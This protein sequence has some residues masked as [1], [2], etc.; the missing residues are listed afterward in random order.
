M[1]YFECVSNYNI[2]TYA[3][4]KKNQSCQT[5]KRSKKNNFILRPSFNIFPSPKTSTICSTRS[6]AQ[7]IP[8]SIN[9][10]I[11]LLIFVSF[12]KFKFCPKL[13]FKSTR[14]QLQIGYLQPTNIW[15]CST[16]KTNKF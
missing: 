3:Y 6:Y 13:Q 14:N 1:A 7:F 11:Y 8:Q 9:L 12:N 4:T 15:N 10:V 5:Q 2:C 16:I